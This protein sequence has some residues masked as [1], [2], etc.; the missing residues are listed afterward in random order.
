M[1]MT[2]AV[3]TLRATPQRTAEARRATPA[4]MT[5]PV[6]VW[7]VDTGMPSALAV[8]I[9][10]DPPSR[11]AEPLM[12]RQLGDAAAHRLDDPPA[13]GHRA[14]ADR[15]VAADR[16]PVRHLEIAAEIAGRIEQDGDDPH[17]LLGIVEAVAERIGGRRDEM[18]RAERPLGTAALARTSSQLDTSMISNDRIMPSVGDRT[19]AM[20]VLLRPVHW[21]PVGRHARRPRR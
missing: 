14:E 3:T 8:K 17:R 13:A 16:D 5:Q 19:I 15:D 11:R 18:Q 4:P 9:I 7:V 1:V 2:Q 12:L 10:T 21:T 20:R 6:M